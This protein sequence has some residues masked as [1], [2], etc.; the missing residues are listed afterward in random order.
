VLGVE[1]GAASAFRALGRRWPRLRGGGL[2]PCVVATDPDEQGAL[3]L[4]QVR[5]ALPAT[6]PVLEVNLKEE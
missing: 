4:A 3:Y 2:V 6:V 5:D 1:S